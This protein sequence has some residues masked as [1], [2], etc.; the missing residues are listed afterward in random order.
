MAHAE[1]LVVFRA[2]R[3]LEPA[4]EEI[5]EAFHV[6]GV[7]QAERRRADQLLRLVAQHRLAARAHEEHATLCV[8]LRNHVVDRLGEHPVALLALAQLA[9]RLLAVRDVAR[10]DDGAPLARARAE[11]PA[12][13]L[14]PMPRPVPVSVAEHELVLGAGS[15]DIP[16]RLGHQLAVF[17]VYSVGDLGLQD[18][19]PDGILA[20]TAQNGIAVGADEEDAPLGVHLVDQVGGVL[21]EAPVAR[22]ALPQG[23]QGARELGVLGRL[24]G[25]ELLAQRLDLRDQLGLRPPRMAHQDPRPGGRRPPGKAF[26]PALPRYTPSGRSKTSGAFPR[27]PSMANRGHVALFSWLQ[28]GEAPLDV[29]GDGFPRRRRGAGE[30]HA[31]SLSVAPDHPGAQREHAAERQ[32]EEQVEL[33]PGRHVRLRLEEAARLG[34]REHLARPAPIGVTAARRDPRG[35]PG[36]SPR[37]LLEGLLQERVERA[38]LHRP[39]RYARD[40]RVVELPPAMRRR[41]R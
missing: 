37:G 1:D 11:A 27:L 15:I 9:K 8:E 17:W 41:G 38:H 3:R 16:E 33:E 35:S 28:A 14:E 22:L 13:A 25:R 19:M 32:R 40:P 29:V 23:L 2:V 26:H 5:D 39:L 10:D 7:Q 36:R 6:V 12:L 4:Q 20:V 18:R 34:E 30:G 24:E 21:G 31:C